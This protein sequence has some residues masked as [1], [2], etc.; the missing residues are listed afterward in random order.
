MPGVQSRATTT[1]AQAIWLAGGDWEPVLRRALSIALENALES[2]AGLAYTNLHEL[3]CADRAYASADPYFHDGVAYREDHD[4]LTFY[5][6]LRGVRTSS[7]E[8]LG[9]WDESVRLAEAVLAVV[10]SPVN[11]MIPMT[12]LAKIA[13]RRGDP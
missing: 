6:C 8:R 10:A 11:R 1:E 12:S 5:T 13:A 7:L 9:H 3:N 2:D 4:L